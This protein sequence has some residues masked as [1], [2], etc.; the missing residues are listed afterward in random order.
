MYGV[1]CSM[2]FKTCP[3]SSQKRHSSAAKRALFRNNAMGLI[4]SEAE[5]VSFNSNENRF[6]LLY[7]TPKKGLCQRILEMPFHGPAQW[8]SPVLNIIA[9]IDK[10]T[11]GFIRDNQRNIVIGQAKGDFIEFQIENLE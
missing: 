1:E 7:L 4:L 5:M 11:S 6:V 10:E 3:S 9:L 2:L 8:T